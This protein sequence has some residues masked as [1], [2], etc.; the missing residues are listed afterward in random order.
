MEIMLETRNLTKKIKGQMILEDV[1]IKVEKGK[2]YGLL[3]PN[4]AG[5]STLLKVITKAMNSTSGDIFLKEK[6]CVHKI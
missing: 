5:K 2:I 4:S 1:S 6:A 3:G